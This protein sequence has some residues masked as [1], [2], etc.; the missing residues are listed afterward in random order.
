MGTVIFST[1]LDGAC[2]QISSA[3]LTTGLL[4]VYCYLPFYE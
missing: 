4:G 2:T 1:D 3:T